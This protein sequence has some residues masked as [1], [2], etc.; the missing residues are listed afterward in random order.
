MK[1]NDEPDAVEGPERPADPIE[2][3]RWE[4][5]RLL[6]AVHMPYAASNGTRYRVGTAMR[7]ITAELVSL[8][9][10]LN[11][12]AEPAAQ[13]AQAPVVPPPPPQE[14]DAEEMAK[15]LAEKH[16]IAY[17]VEL[18]GLASWILAVVGARIQT[19]RERDAAQA[20]A[21]RLRAALEGIMDQV[22]TDENESDWHGTLGV[23]VIR[24]LARRALEGVKGI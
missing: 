4:R 8:R 22:G 6:E 1:T 23:I 7:A 5:D 21:E 13:A 15:H 12:R 14:Q 19:I 18:G 17:P 2:A 11:A 10:M 24:K 3:I 20:T 9:T 16:G